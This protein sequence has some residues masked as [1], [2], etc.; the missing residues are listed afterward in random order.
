MSLWILIMDND[1]LSVWDLG[2]L[3]GRTSPGAA[4]V[5]FWVF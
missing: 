3:S 1:E 5:T 4:W 2:K